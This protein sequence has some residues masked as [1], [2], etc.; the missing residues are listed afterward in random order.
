MQESE[1]EL[2]SRE[3]SDVVPLKKRRVH[4]DKPN[5]TPSLAQQARKISA[6]STPE[7]QEGVS[8]EGAVM[9]HPFDVLEF[10]RVGLQD[11]VYRKFRLG[12]YP[13]EATIDLHRMTLQEGQRELVRFIRDCFQLGLRTV[14]VNHGRGDRDPDN[15][16]RMKSHVAHWLPQMD[17]VLAYHSAQQHH[18]GSG[19]LY[20]LIRK[21]DAQKQKNRERF[22][23]R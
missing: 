4:F 8:T 18:G 7:E 1:S 11:G 2:F 12:K 5:R 22:R 13:I 14:T 20:V 21:A 10:K 17:A 23:S 3:V 19:V 9:V 16:A 6:Q 15:P